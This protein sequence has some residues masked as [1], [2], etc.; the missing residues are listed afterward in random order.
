MSDETG[1]LTGVDKEFL[2]S[3]KNGE[4]YY[5]GTNAKQ[6]RYERREAI[7]KRTRQA[8]HDF[9]QLYDTVDEHE[10]NR[11]FNVSEDPTT[12]EANQ[13]LDS[14]IDTVAFLYL[15]MNGGS[16][17][18]GA[19]YRPLGRPFQ[20]ILEPGVEKAEQQRATQPSRFSVVNAHLTV[21][22]SDIEKTDVE[23]MI[24]KVAEGDLSDLSGGEA[25]GLLELADKAEN[26]GSL[27]ISGWRELG[28]KIQQRRAE[29]DDI[30][31]QE[32]WEEIRNLSD[33]EVSERFDDESP[34][35]KER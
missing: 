23:R 29:R 24:D 7:A 20:S 17:R 30:L 11:I 1:F 6:Q 35:S 32:D 9:A 4:E 21:D 19:Y 33:E 13:L 8:F 5:T 31:T 22:A 34:D 25:R 3:Q 10:R 16:D 2:K 18:G 28:E 12:D 14:L 26:Q 15:S 27:F